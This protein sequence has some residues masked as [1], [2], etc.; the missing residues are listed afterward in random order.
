MRNEAQHAGHDVGKQ[1]SADQDGP[2]AGY[3]LPVSLWH[4]VTVPNLRHGGTCQRVKESG[5]HEGQAL[6]PRTDVVVVIAKYSAVRY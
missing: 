1:R 4:Y 3:H 5:Q 6:V 2:H